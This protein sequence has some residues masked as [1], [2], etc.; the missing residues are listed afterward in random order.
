MNNKK[1]IYIGSDLGTVKRSLLE[2]EEFRFIHGDSWALM[3]GRCLSLS[4]CEKE[5]KEDTGENYKKWC[6][7]LKKDTD[8][9]SLYKNKK[10]NLISD[11]RLGHKVTYTIASKRLKNSKED[12][13]FFLEETI[14]PAQRVFQTIKAGMLPSGNKW[15]WNKI[16]RN[17]ELIQDNFNNHYKNLIKIHQLRNKLK[18]ELNKTKQELNF[19]FSAGHIYVKVNDE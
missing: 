13:E 16:K 15:S 5:E 12:L 18:K 10:N 1:V 4:C 11:G 3:D 19:I 9:Y 7:E 2:E 17:N 8:L 6:N 14:K